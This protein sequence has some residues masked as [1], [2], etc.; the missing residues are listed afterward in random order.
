VIADEHC[1]IAS[2][3]EEVEDLLSD[4]VGV[5]EKVEDSMVPANV[6]LATEEILISSIT[7]TAT[8]S[9]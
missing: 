6:F 9:K 4:D 3:G 8:S 5:S 1:G 2:G 7:T